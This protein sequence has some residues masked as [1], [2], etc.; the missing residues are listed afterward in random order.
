MG[1]ERERE[2]ERERVHIIQ[3]EQDI[4]TGFCFQDAQLKSE[5]KSEDCLITLPQGL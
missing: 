1:E 5:L 3:L 2:R 4:G